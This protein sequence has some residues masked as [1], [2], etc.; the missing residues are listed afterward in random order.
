MA[1]F[2]LPF[3]VGNENLPGPGFTV[4]AGVFRATR[5]HEDAAGLG[6]ASAG[7][8]PIDPDEFGFV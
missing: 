6:L 8:L 2:L 1:V 3:G 5:K 7:Q 4:G